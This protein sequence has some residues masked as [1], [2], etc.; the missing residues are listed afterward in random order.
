M[1]EKELKNN[2]KHVKKI[3]QKIHKIILKKTKIK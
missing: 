2:N 1:P 3:L